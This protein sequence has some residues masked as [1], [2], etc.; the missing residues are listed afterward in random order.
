[1]SVHASENYIKIYRI[2]VLVYIVSFAKKSYNA[3]PMASPESEDRQDEKLNLEELLQ[4]ADVPGGD[5]DV[6]FQLIPEADIDLLDE[7]PEPNEEELA[8][9]E[10]EQVAVSDSQDDG[11]IFANIDPRDPISLYMKEMSQTPLLTAKEEVELAKQIEAGKKASEEMAEQAGRITPKRRLELRKLIEDGWIARQ[12]LISANTRLVISVA[13]K[14]MGR[15]VP[16]LDLISE[17]NIGLIR[18]SKK[19]DYKLGHKFSTY[20]TWW[21]RQ[22]I[23]R[24]ISDQA[25]T[26]RVPV[27]MGEAIN[28][29]LRQQHRLTQKLHRQPTPEELAEALDDTSVKKVEQMLL[30]NRRPYSLE[31]PLDDEDESSLGDLLED[32]AGDA[33][34]DE[35]AHH[36]LQETLSEVLNDL[37]PREMRILQLRYGLLDGQAYTLEEVGRKMG[38]TRERIRQIEAQALSRLRNPMI[39]RRLR[40][41]LEE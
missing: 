4:K 41:Y 32:E 11:D 26:V 6:D 5:P 31:A 30:V 34:D 25:R 37:P 20:A 7:L 36:M 39:R 13:K 3:I 1:V 8:Q 9:T 29:M 10:Q 2:G 33:P 15:G 17:G 35:A 19:F 14:Y 16:F 22:A 27:H 40:D 38:V 23:T 28:K 12:G 21:I 18:G 24:G